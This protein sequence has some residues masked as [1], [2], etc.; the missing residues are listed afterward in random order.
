MDKDYSFLNDKH[1]STHADNKEIIFD[2]YVVD[3]KI[4]VIKNGND[5]VEF[6]R[7]QINNDEWDIDENDLKNEKNI[8]DV[9]I[10]LIDE[11]K[12][13]TLFNNNDD[14]FSLFGRTSVI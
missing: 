2:N 1:F 10:K 6:I 8:T 14:S 12:F 13:N 11:D 9:L 7:K 3:S 4:F 5:F